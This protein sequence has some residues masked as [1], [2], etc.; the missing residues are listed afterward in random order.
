MNCC[1]LCQTYPRTTAIFFTVIVAALLWTSA[2]GTGTAFAQSAGTPPAGQAPAK[3]SK[4]AKATKAPAEAP[5]EAPAAP[6]VDYAA[7]TS[8]LRFRSIGPAVM[9]GRVDD[10][11][12][13]ESDP[14]IVYVATA[15][16]GVLKTTNAGTTWT[17]IFDDQE[18]ST[19]GDI[20]VA[21]SDPSIVWVG[22][23]EPNNR[24]SSSWG[25]G[26]Y[27]STDAGKTWQHMGLRA[28]E[29]IGRI[30]IHPTNPSVAYVAAIGKLWGPS[31]ERGVFKTTDGGKTWT[32]VLFINEDTGVIDIA[33][34]H[35]SPDTLL[36]GA[37]QRRRTVW[38]FNGSGPHGGIYKTTDG[39]ATWKKSITGLPWDPNFRATTQGAGA[40]LDPNIAALAAAFGF[41]LPQ[42]APAPPATQ[43][44]GPQEIGRIGLNFFR[45]D[46]N[47]VYALVEHRNGGT[48]RSEDKGDTWVRMSD[49]NPRAMYYSKIHIDPNNDQRLWVLGANMFNSEDGGRT[50][51]Q[52]RVQRIHGDYHALWIN[53]QNSDHVLAGSD[54]GIHWSWDGGR[55]WDAVMTVPLGQFYEIGVDMRQPYNVCGGLQDNNTWCGPSATMDTAGIRNSDWFTIGGGDGFYAQMDPTDANIV[56]AESQD[57]NVLRRDLRTHESRSIRPQEAAGEARFR[58]QWNSP[59]V[60]SAH[61][62]ATIY[63]GGNFLFKSTDRGDNW[64]RISSD[65][66][67]GQDRDKLPIMGK[68]P[69]RDTLS[70]HDGVQQ[71]PAATSVSESAINASVLW[72]GTDDGNLQVTRDGG[73]TWKNVADKVPGVPKGTYVSRVIASRHAEGTAYATF[74]GHRMDDF[75]IYVFTTTDFGETWKAIRNGIPDNRGIA[76]VIR[77]HHKNADLLFVGTEYG[78]YFSFDRGA[79]WT[80]IKNGLPTV[81]VDDIL[82]HPRDNDLIFG[83]HGRSIWIL[84]DINALEGMSDKVAASDFH[85]FDLSP[86]IM[87]RVAGRTT[88]ASTGHKLFNGANP[89]NGVIIDYYLKNKIEAPAPPAGAAPPAGGGPGGGGGGSGQGGGAQFAQL[90]QQQ[91]QGPIRITILDSEGR[92]VRELRGAGNAGI[93]RV[94][95]DFRGTSPI[96]PGA[97]PGGGGGGGGFGGGLGGGPRVDPGTF[98]VRVRAGDKESTRTVVV[99]EDPRLVLS[100]ADRAA[101]RAA[102][103]Q[104]GQ[105]IGPFVLTQRGL[106]QLRQALNTMVEGWKRPGPAAGRPPENVIKAGEDFLKRIDDVYPKFANIPLATGTALGAAGPPLTF[107]APPA[108]QRLQQ[109][110]GQLESFTAAP[111][112]WQLENIKLLIA[113]LTPALPLARKLLTEDLPAFNK[114]MNDAGV[115]HL[116][117]QIP[118]LGARPGQGRPPEGDPD[119]Q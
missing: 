68:V 56:Y 20:T 92:T 21:P 71:W 34:D 82:I 17:P 4:A 88:S 14:S 49:V 48:F 50:F 58:F 6:K 110:A 5:P 85:L 53:P 73:K 1:Y 77:E 16:G 24:Q 103:S 76:N 67:N 35:Q 90:A 84:D 111:T 65:L 114:L 51:V 119:N 117:V 102:I 39:G 79:N 52:N 99:E 47:I 96:P 43:P 86:S 93:N 32:N 22:T 94:V 40:Q 80:R 8:G 78:A 44:A 46:T 81:P 10:F 59:I 106:Q 115:P 97:G 89:P 113:E 33:M 57:G 100:A 64:T 98:T 91:A 83:T 74:D 112:A 36:A 62:P 116:N 23:G 9:G 104:V 66:T 55:T 11:A 108:L 31:K 60:I 118:G 37:Y 19:I 61:N 105:V 45:G 54:G 30:V 29:S 12:V 7:I 26:V 72:V 70:R 87:W 95:W 69:D 107:Q 27:K 3:A 63:Y 42:Q 18:V 41:Q 2:P 28:T 38:G 15:S 109:I 25:N 101:R 13:V 75:G